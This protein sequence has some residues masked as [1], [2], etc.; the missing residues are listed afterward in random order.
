MA[1]NKVVKEQLIKH[2]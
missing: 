2:L 1:R